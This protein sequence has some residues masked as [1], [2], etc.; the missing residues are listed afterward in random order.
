M[1]NELTLI[2]ADVAML[3]LLPEEEPTTHGV[4]LLASC[5][6]T[7]PLWTSDSIPSICCG[8]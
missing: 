5:R 6:V 7:C 4:H 8:D 3:Q 1:P 2:T